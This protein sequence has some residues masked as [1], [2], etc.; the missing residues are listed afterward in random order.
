[1]SGQI[2]SVNPNLPIPPGTNSN[3]S[4]NPKST[5]KSLVMTANQ[6]QED[7]KYDVAPKREGFQSQFKFYV[8]PSVL[9]LLL[10]TTILFIVCKR[11]ILYGIV[12]LIV[13]VF[14]IML[15]ANLRRS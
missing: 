11:H 2:L 9:Y 14:L 4:S 5:I 13:A 10:I 15:E 12:L 1:M 3:D 8:N 6:A 7:A